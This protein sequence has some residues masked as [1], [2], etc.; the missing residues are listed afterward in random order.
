M[1]T[2][3]IHKYLSLIYLDPSMVARGGCWLGMDIYINII[4]NNTIIYYIYSIYILSIYLS[5]IHLPPFIK[6]GLYVIERDICELFGLSY[7]W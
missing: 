4:K 7:C 2:R 6:F 1:L 3:I 5:C